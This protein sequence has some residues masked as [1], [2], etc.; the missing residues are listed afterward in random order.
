[1]REMIVPR[2]RV[3]G[4]LFKE[5][6]IALAAKPVHPKGEGSF[7]SRVEGK[8]NRAWSAD[9]GCGALGATPALLPW[10]FQMPQECAGE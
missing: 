6:V 5:G 8:L 3:E 1:M 2:S 4:S 9:A 7:A 10:R